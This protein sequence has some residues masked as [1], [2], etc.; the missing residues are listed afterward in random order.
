[1]R[2]TALF[3]IATSVG[4]V[5]AVAGWAAIPHARVT[6]ST[7]LAIDAIQ[8]NAKNLSPLHWDD[9]SVVFN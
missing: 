4:L 2:K 5:I 1:M 3:L 6:P 9:Y 8:S 7:G